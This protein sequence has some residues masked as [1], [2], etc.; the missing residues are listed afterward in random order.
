MLVPR[1][2][3]AVSDRGSNPRG[4][5]RHGGILNA[6][7]L[8]LHE[9]KLSEERWALRRKEEEQLRATVLAE[10]KAALSEGSWWQR[11]RRR[12]VAMKASNQKEK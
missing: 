10:T 2:L 3:E 4:S 6:R 11:A 7:E 1:W 8:Y 9:K 12:Q 5:T